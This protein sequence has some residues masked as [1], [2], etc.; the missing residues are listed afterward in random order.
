MRN[1]YLWCYCG[2]AR[3]S[4]MSCGWETFGV[5]SG[6][7]STRHLPTLRN[8]CCLFIYLFIFRVAVLAGEGV[9]GGFVGGGREDD[10]LC[11]EISPRVLH[12][13]AAMPAKAKGPKKNNLKKW[14]KWGYKTNTTQVFS[15]TRI[16]QLR[17]FFFLFGA[18]LFLTVRSLVCSFVRSFCKEKV[19]R[20]RP[21][22]SSHS[23]ETLSLALH[24]G[25]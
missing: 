2:W 20:V 6:Q 25:F 8:I 19:L 16:H 11:R 21:N 17:N 1:K 9:E 10:G 18:S 22:S 5:I 24:C 14:E 23:L 12:P 13:S 4:T 7:E 15:S 3:K